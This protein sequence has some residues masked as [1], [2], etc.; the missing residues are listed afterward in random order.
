MA[1]MAGEVI[2]VCLSPS[3]ICFE[4]KSGAKFEGEHRLDELRM[5]QDEVVKIWLDPSVEVNKRAVDVLAKADVIVVCPGSMYGS[6]L[7][8]FM[9][10]GFSQVFIKSK[11]KKILMTNVMSVRNENH[12]FDQ[13]KYI[14]LFEKYVG[15]KGIFDFVLMADLTKLNQIKLKK[16]LSNYDFE[17]SV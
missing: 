12:G 17:Y 13:N 9:V 2:P 6:V 3:N 5:S 15:K 8:N 11:A 10:D 4:V 7:V 1:D 16:V 14:K